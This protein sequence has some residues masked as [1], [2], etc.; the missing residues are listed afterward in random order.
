MFDTIILLTG[1]IEQGPL[2]ALLR[3]HHPDL[4]IHSVSAVDAFAAFDAALLKRARLLSFASPI[5]VPAHVLGALGFG[6]YN[7]H[8]GPPE[9]PGWAPAHFALYDGASE[10][11]AT[12]HVMA[13]SL[14]YRRPGPRRP[15]LRASGAAVLAAVEGAR[16]PGRAIARAAAA[17]ERQE[18]LAPRLSG[19]LQHS[20]RHLQGGA[21][22]PH[23]RVRRQS[24]RHDADDQPAR[25]GISCGHPATGS[26]S[27]ERSPGRLRQRICETSTA[28]RSFG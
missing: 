15:R 13:D 16:K 5:I 10:F 1:P 6:A 24:F 12:V 9:Y 8:P 26:F 23:A 27:T 25:R 11:G 20:A 3:S 18:E 7:F 4:T 28:S 19:D 21:R 17:M 2:A 22:A 14:G